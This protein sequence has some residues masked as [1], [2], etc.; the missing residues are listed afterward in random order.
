VVASPQVPLPSQVRALV[1]VPP[2]Q[3]AALPQV[4]PD[5]TCSHLW[6]FVHSPV[7]PHSPFCAHMPLGS[8]SPVATGVH[9]P[10]C[11]VRLQ[12]W[13]IPHELPVVS[14]QTPSTHLPAAQ[15]ALDEQ[16]S[17]SCPP[18]LQAPVPV[19][20][21]APVA[22]SALLVQGAILQPPVVHAKLPQAVG[23]AAGQVLPVPEQN[24]AGVKVDP[25]HFAAAHMAVEVWQAPA[26]SQTLVRPHGVVP[27]Q[28]V[29]VLPDAI[30]EQVPSPF[31]LH[32]LQAPQ[33]GL[34]QQTVSTQ[35]PVLH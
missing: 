18:V 27:A 29:S 32:A 31:R 5:A 21:V 22:Q 14:Q 30:P 25:L 13:H 23:V 33:L 1:W 3:E 34:P 2:V 17:P 7:L 26:P 16:L 12:A 9:V 10:R 8:A 4:V 35:L 19:S 15:G 20:Q 28:R 11:P 24:A 6:L